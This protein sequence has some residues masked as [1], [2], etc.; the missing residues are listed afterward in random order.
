MEK[1]IDPESDLSIFKNTFFLSAG[2]TNAEREMSIPL[3]TSKLIDIATAHANRLGIGNPDMIDK[4]TGWVLSR[5][6]IEMD[7]YPLI[8]EDYSISTWV[9]SWNRHF[10]E[11]AFMIEGTRGDVKGKARS[12]WMILDTE[13]HS[14]AGLDGMN[15]NPENIVA[16]KCDIERQGKH[17]PIVTEEEA[18]S[19]SGKFLIADRV[20][21]HVFLYSDL[22]AYRHVNTVKYV[23]LLMNQF[24]LKEHD[25]YL[26]K[27]IELSFLKEGKYGEPLQILRHTLDATGVEGDSKMPAYAFLLRSKK[28]KSPVLFSK[29]FLQKRSRPIPSL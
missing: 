27:R 16:G 8:D 19:A 1:I 3:L 21:E 2:E 17:F 5:L 25:E 7:Q 14:N 26:I 4:N 11:R 12:I 9:E 18:A 23:Q 15:F 22:D 24:D 6:T 13:T 28:D 10:S 29:I 20:K